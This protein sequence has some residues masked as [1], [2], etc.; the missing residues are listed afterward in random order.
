LS[1]GVVCEFALG[2]SPNDTFWVEVV[3][4]LIVEF[5]MQEWR[6]RLERP[7][8]RIG[9]LILG[10]PSSWAELTDR[11]EE[12]IGQLGVEQV[13]HREA[14]IELEALWNSATRSET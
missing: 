12:A 7:N 10:L 4:E 11:L 8:A 3:D 1:S 6:L 14:D 5:R 13:V 9:D 2:R